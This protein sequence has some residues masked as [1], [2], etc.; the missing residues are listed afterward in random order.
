MT[1]LITG[2]RG[3]VARNLLNLVHER[4]IAVRAA[5]NEPD[6]LSVP[7][8]VPTVKLNLKDPATFPAALEGITSV[9]LYAE[10][11][12][13]DAFIEQAVDVEHIVLLS[14]ASVLSADAENDPLAKSHLD[15]EKALTASPITSTFL[16]PG[17]FA[18]NALGLAWGIKSAGAVSLPY[19][20]S[21]TDPIHEADVAEAALAVLTEPR[22][23]GKSYTLSGPESVTF[24]EQ[25]DD[26]AR[27]AARPITINVV[28]REEWK[29]QMAE[30]IPGT[31][32]D[33]L[34]DLWQ[35]S[36][37]SPVQTTRTVETLTGHP[38]RGF[39]VW[40]EDHAAEFQA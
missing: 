1:I 6:K 16:R 27:A 13:I 14:S 29:D 8:G 18:G 32:A 20:N 35:S 30:Y 24:A 38:A 37:G 33:A 9:F 17:S 19:P 11:S 5:S 21:H 23:R 25:I 4:G 28:T 36:D 34:L 39:A 3:A 2:S 12:N 15:V 31:F 10:A 7:E 26:L 22:L 40:A